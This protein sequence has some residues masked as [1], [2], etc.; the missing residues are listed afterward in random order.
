[1][2]PTSGQTNP[3]G[4]TLETSSLTTTTTVNILDPDT[5]LQLAMDCNLIDASQISTSVANAL[6]DIQE[7][8]ALARK[9]RAARLP[10]APDGSVPN[11]RAVEKIAEWKSKHTNFHI[12]TDELKF[13][14]ELATSRTKKAIQ[15]TQKDEERK[16]KSDEYKAKLKEKLLNQKSAEEKKEA[17]EVAVAEQALA[18]QAAAAAAGAAK[19]EPGEVNV[20]E[21]DTGN[22]FED[23]DFDDLSDEKNSSGP[24]SKKS[25]RPPTIS[26]PVQ[27]KFPKVVE[28]AGERLWFPMDEVSQR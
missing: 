6:L 27:M 1:M 20:D 11:S 23:T 15:Q 5:L 4:F 3:G 16:K 18:D 14:P 19:S 12:A 13:N 10:V 9:K 21:D 17:E 25:N 22:L 28:M 2:G 7:D 24:Q 8:A 26:P